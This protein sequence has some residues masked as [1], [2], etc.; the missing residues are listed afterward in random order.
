MSVY[1]GY[2]TVK[3]NPRHLVMSSSKSC[4]AVFMFFICVDDVDEKVYCK[5]FQLC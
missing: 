1:D 4:T 5:G 2:I 3:Q